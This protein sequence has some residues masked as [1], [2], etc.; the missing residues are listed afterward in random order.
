LSEDACGGRLDV[1]RID[2]LAARRLGNSPERR[3]RQHGPMPFAN[4]QFDGYRLVLL[5]AS[6]R[7]VL[8]ESV[9]SRRQL[10]SISVPRWTRAAK[11]ITDL[12]RQRWQ[13]R[14]IVL[15]FLGDRPGAGG[16]VVAEALDREERER[17]LNGHEWLHLDDIEDPSF[18]QR[19]RDI[20]RLL[21]SQGATGRGAFSRLGWIEQ[22]LDWIS[23]I[24][25]LD[26]WRFLG[27]I[28]QINASANSSLVR[29]VAGR[30]RYW[31]KAA[32]SP[33][34][35]E[36]LVTSTLASLFPEYLPEIV[37]FHPDWNAWLMRDAGNPLSDCDSHTPA[38]TH[39]IVRRLA[40][41]QRLSVGYV[42]RLLGDGCHDHRMPALRAEIPG[43]TPYLEEAMRMQNIETGVCVSAPRL[44]RIATIIEEASFR[45]EDIRIPDALIHCDIDFQNILI[46]GERCVFTDWAEASV[47]NPLT[48]F[49][50]IRIQFVQAD[51]ASTSILRLK[52]SYYEIWR[53]FITEREFECALSLVPLIALASNL[54]CRRDWLITDNL[55]RSQSQSYARVLARQMDR[56][57]HLTEQSIAVYT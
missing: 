20:V 47:G 25:T 16:I 4:P 45:L 30:H 46:D 50:Q 35:H 9:F 53:D 36:A 56:A 24:T 11:E 12:I 32:G 39:R 26:R 49:E 22:A 42:P 34:A 40:E 38:R 7:R 51:H 8:L 13:L 57:A 28:Q 19:D 15:D 41:L 10:P 14:A 54:C 37:G 27:G 48:T 55:H 33:E 18:S 2:V 43:L 3:H 5:S 44:R 17:Y 31:F 6:T 1:R 29:F 21:V 23:E 52:Q